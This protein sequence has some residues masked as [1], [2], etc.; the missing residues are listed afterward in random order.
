MAHH[1]A[2]LAVLRIAAAQQLQIAYQAGGFANSFLE[3]AM[4]A[5]GTI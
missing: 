1:E 2:A 4:D 3:T 5:V